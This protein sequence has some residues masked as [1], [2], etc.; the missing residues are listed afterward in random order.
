MR[1]QTGLLVLVA[2]LAVPTMGAA[3]DLTL[4]QRSSIGAHVAKPRDVMEYWSGNQMVTDDAQQRT[5][6]DMDARTLTAIDKD[7]HTYFIQTFD[8]MEKQA[9]SM[10]QA[11]QKRIASLPPQAKQLM[12]NLDPDAPVTVKPTGKSEKIAGYDAK[13]YA[14]E[15]GTTKGSI[16]IAEALQPP[17]SPEK[18]AAFRKAMSGMAGPG[19]KLAAA[20]MQLKGLPLRTTMF[21]PMGPEQMAVTTEVVE[22]SEKAPPPDVMKVPDGYQKVAPPSFEMP[23]RGGPPRHP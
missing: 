14:I 13:E 15:G 23:E 11:M 18:A 10:K 20:M 9:A 5:I 3:K 16:W 17:V 4:H 22:V 6:I 21:G 19:G 8:E 7:Q 12:G 1:T 2:A